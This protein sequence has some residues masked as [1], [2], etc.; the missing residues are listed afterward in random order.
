MRNRYLDPAAG[1]FLTPDPIGYVDGPNSYQGFLNNPVDFRDPLGTDTF[2]VKY[3]PGLADADVYVT[4]QFLRSAKDRGMTT[5][6]FATVARDYVSAATSTWHPL[7]PRIIVASPG[8]ATEK[9]SGWEFEVSPFMS[10]IIMLSYPAGI[11]SAHLIPT[12]KATTKTYAHE[13]GHLLGLT[14]Y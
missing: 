12:G 11:A 14:D 9:G 8:E 5:Q 4:I 10:Q 7:N 13:F 1:R 2:V 3:G 6:R